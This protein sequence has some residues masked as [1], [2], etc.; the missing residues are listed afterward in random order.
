MVLPL[1][2]TLAA[3]EEVHSTMLELPHYTALPAPVDHC[4]ITAN[5]KA[6]VLA[7][8]SSSHVT[9]SVTLPAMSFGTKRHLEECKLIELMRLLHVEHSSQ[10]LSS[11]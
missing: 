2:T 8:Y 1:V 10:S 11:I 3:M 7:L 9:T 5:A 4:C 6:R